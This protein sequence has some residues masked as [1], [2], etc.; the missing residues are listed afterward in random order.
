MIGLF[1]NEE[2][3]VKGPDQ[4][5]EGAVNIGVQLDIA[6]EEA[7]EPLVSLECTKYGNQILGALN[8]VNLR[9]IELLDPIGKDDVVNVPAW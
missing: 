6:N 5:T 4:L 2:S 9:Q 7:I 3:G 1:P 8:V